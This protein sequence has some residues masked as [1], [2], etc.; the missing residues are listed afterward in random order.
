MLVIGAVGAALAATEA[1]VID[2][3]CYTDEDCGE[4]RSCVTRGANKGRCIEGECLEDADCGDPAFV[5]RDHR[6]RPRSVPADGAAPD[7][8]TG[9][10]PTSDGTGD[11]SAQDDATSRC[12]AEMVA[13]GQAFCI[14]IYEASRPDA[15]E[16][17]A[18]SDD[19]RATSRKGVL[20]WRVAGNAEAQAACQAAGKDLCTPLQ[21]RTAC[22]GPGDT[23]YAYGDDYDPTIC[24]GIDRFCDCGAGGACADRD[25]CPF[26]G[27]YHVCS[28]AFGLRPTGDSPGCR[29]TEG[30][31]DLNG[32]LWEHVKGGD[33]TQVRGGAYNC[34]D[35]AALH[36]CDYIPGDWTPSARGFRCCAPLQGR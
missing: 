6:C 11:A 27:C 18:G 13:V 3:V 5:C 14:D 34:S 8:A 24:N 23:D 30:V 36:R 31:F 32:N 15:T 33:D 35:S 20:P 12:P 26:A 17:S 19:S 2:S 25:P 1:C 4:G 10:G 16:Q 21:W 28:A 22:R 9:D 29:S 7:G